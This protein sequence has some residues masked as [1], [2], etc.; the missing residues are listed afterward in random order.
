MV[1]QS[2]ASDLVAGDYND[3]A[4]LFVLH[5][6]SMDTDGDG[7]DDD[8]EM[9]YFDNLDHDGTA[10]T[11]YDTQTDAEEFRAGTDPTNGD[12]VLQ[13]LTITSPRSDQTT[14]LWY[15]VPG[16]AYRV[17]YKNSVTDPEW[18]DLPSIVTATSTTGSATDLTAGAEAHR[19]YRVLL[20]P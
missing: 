19:Y 7:L 8:W 9:A 14:I 6:G 5:L 2:S 20:A 12:S 4:D 10:D 11:D 17:Q 1:F 16:R 18:T 3:R 13:V 15:A